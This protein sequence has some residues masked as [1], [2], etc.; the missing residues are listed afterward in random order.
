[1]TRKFK[2][3]EVVF[4]IVAEQDDLP[5]RGNAI[6]SDDEDFD[7]K[8]ALEIEE[9]LE[10]GNVWAWAAVTVTASWAGFS[11]SDHLGGCSYKGVDDFRAAGGYFQDMLGQAV[12]ALLDEVREAGWEI[13][14]TEDAVEEA[15]ACELRKDMVA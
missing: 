11:G 4:T 3:E 5:I 2:P 6:V 10:Q 12:D 9:E 14:C 8:V 7:E 13:E 1:M 15:V